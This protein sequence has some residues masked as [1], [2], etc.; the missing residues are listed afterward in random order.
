M[1][2]KQKLLFK[3]QLYLHGPPR[4]WIK[5]TPASKIQWKSRMSENK[6]R[7]CACSACVRVRAT[8]EPGFWKIPNPEEVAYLLPLSLQVCFGSGHLPPRKPP[9]Q[10]QELMTEKYIL[11]PLIVVY[12]VLASKMPL[13]KHVVFLFVCIKLYKL[14][15]P[16]GQILPATCFRTDG[17]LRIAIFKKIKLLR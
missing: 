8:R 10:W 13:N 9:Q 2:F 15:E 17:E 12:K 4:N 7:R 16:V 5:Q 11:R 3:E 14:L 1:Q 6:G